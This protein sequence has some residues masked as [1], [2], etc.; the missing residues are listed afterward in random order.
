M[1][2]AALEAAT[3]AIKEAF[4]RYYVEGT[5]DDDLYSPPSRAPWHLID[6]STAEPEVNWPGELIQKYDNPQHAYDHRERLAAQAAIEAYLAALPDEDG[7]VEEAREAGSERRRG[8]YPGRLVGVESDLL[9]RLAD[10]LEATRA[11]AIPEG[12]QLVPE[13][14]EPLWI[15]TL[16]HSMCRVSVAGSGVKEQAEVWIMRVLA[17]APETSDDR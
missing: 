1:N 17:A 8:T 13:K 10:A 2:E 16:A 7:L 6:T 14:P 4:I 11:R 3:G 15:D 9:R 12:W 5:S